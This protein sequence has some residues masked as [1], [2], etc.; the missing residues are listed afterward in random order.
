MERRFFEGSLGQVAQEVS[1]WLGTTT[2]IVLQ[3]YSVG[4]YERPRYFERHSQKH[5]TVRVI[6]DA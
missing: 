1:E 3:S 5:A 4:E 6:P 2:E